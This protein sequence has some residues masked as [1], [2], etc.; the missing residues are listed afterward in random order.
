MSCEFNSLCIITIT[1]ESGIKLHYYD[2]THLVKEDT[3]GNK[4]RGEFYFYTG[5]EEEDSLFL[6]VYRALDL[7]SDYVSQ[8]LLLDHFGDEHFA[9]VKWERMVELDMVARTVI[10]NDMTI[11]EMSKYFKEQEL[12]RDQILKVRDMIYRMEYPELF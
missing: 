1:L 4:Y 6:P 9:L 8:E 12:N 7:I 11:T 5:K 3:N 2:G 10:N